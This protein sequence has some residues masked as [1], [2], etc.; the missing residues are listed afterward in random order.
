MRIGRRFLDAD[1]SVYDFEYA[2][3]LARRRLPGRYAA[4]ALLRCTQLALTPP[5]TTTPEAQRRRAATASQKRKAVSRGAMMDRSIAWISGATFCEAATA[6]GTRDRRGYGRERFAR[7]E[8]PRRKA[9]A[10]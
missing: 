2:G 3:I 4:D 7:V 9:R 1:I 5:D 10:A 8:G 6:L